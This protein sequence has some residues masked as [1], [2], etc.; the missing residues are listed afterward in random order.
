[1]FEGK[2]KQNFMDWETPSSHILYWECRC[3]WQCCH[4]H[5]L[6]NDVFTALACG[7][8]GYMV[9]RSGSR[10][11][12]RPGGNF[13]LTNQKQANMGHLT[14]FLYS[15]DQHCYIEKQTISKTEFLR[16][17]LHTT[18]HQFVATVKLILLDWTN[19]RIYNLFS[20]VTKCISYDT[21]DV[22]ISFCG[23]LRI[24]FPVTDHSLTT[25]SYQKCQSFEVC[26]RGY[27]NWKT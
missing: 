3:L 24:C 18:E 13:C 4:G 6:D 7:M 23:Y 27:D 9:H 10:E 8:I 25:Y 26:I 19:G 11:K 15:N 2:S 12:R 17:A 16:P 22:A 5:G 20:L 21:I 14:W 1:M